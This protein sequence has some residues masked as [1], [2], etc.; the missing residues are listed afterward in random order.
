MTMFV[1]VEHRVQRRREQGDR[2]ADARRSRR[3][4]TSRVGARAFAL[5]SSSAPAQRGGAPRRAPAGRS[6]SRRGRAP[7]CAHRLGQRAPPRTRAGDRCRGRCTMR[8]R[9]CSCAYLT[10]ASG[11]R[12]ARPASRCRRRRPGPASARAGCAGARRRAAA[13]AAASR[14]RRSARARRA[15]PP[16]APWRAPASPSAR[17]GRCTAAAPRA[18]ATPAPPRLRAPVLQHLVVDA[19]GGAA[20]RQLA[21]GDQ[22][23][24]AEEVAHGRGRPAAAGRPCLPSGAAAGRRAAGRRSRPR[25]PRRTRGRAP[26]PTRGCR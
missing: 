4:A 14:R 9:L 7:S 10:I 15:A 21:Q 3:T 1:E 8:D 20:Q 22:V 25:R 23:A 24:L 17:R 16:C 2:R 6:G 19:V 12:S 26:S 5:R 13:A 11:Q 18:S